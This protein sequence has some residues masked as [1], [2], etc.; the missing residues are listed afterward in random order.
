MYKD[1]ASKIQK[2]IDEEQGN[3][4]LPNTATASDGATQAP[5]KPGAPQFLQDFHGQRRTTL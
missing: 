2:A 1:A 5:Q 3:T 4:V